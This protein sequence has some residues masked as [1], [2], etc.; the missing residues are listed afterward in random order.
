MIIER[1]A[2]VR[3]LRGLTLVA[4][5]P[6]IRAAPDQRPAATFRLSRSYLAR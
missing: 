2:V 4:E 3:I 1:D 6:P 5:H